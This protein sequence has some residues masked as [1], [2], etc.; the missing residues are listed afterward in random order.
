MEE[1]VSEGMEALLRIG[2]TKG[3]FNLNYGRE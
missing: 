3:M 1:V 2:A